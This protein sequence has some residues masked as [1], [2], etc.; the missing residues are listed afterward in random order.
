MVNQVQGVITKTEN[1]G[2]LPEINFY[3]MGV[4]LNLVWVEYQEV[5]G[6][7]HYSFPLIGFQ[8]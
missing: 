2:L 4:W 1:L 3:K 7:V 8:G 5:Q 6:N